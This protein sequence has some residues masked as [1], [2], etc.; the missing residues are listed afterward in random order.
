MIGVVHWG[1]STLSDPYSLIKFIYHKAA[2]S[3]LPLPV[4]KCLLN[5]DPITLNH[6]P[7]GHNYV[8]QYPHMPQWGLLN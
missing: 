2:R 6:T 8:H 7:L 3:G 4:Q 5:L 1:E